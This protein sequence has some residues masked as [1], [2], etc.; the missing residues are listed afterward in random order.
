MFNESGNKIKYTNILIRCDEDFLNKVSEMMEYYS[1]ATRAGFIRYAV[2]ELFLGD[3]R[4]NKY[5]YQAGIMTN[6]TR[7]QEQGIATND[8]ERIQEL[9]KLSAYNLEIELYRRGFFKEETLSNGDIKTNRI[10]TD[11][12]GNMVMW[13]LHNHPGEK[14][15]FYKY[16]PYIGDEIFAALKKEGLLKYD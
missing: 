15:P 8:A 4:K 16:N 14:V 11:T 13:I 5:G 6:K 12:S 10:L 3:Y 2:M 1:A 7:K 9:K